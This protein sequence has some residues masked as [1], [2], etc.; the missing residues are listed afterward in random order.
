MSSSV[1]DWR[2]CGWANTL[3]VWFVCV[4]VSVKILRTV[5]L[6]PKKAFVCSSK[7]LGHDGGSYDQKKKKKKKKNSTQLKKRKTAPSVRKYTK[8][9][10]LHKFRRCGIMTLNWGQFLHVR[11]KKRHF[12]ELLHILPNLLIAAFV[13]WLK[14]SVGVLFSMIEQSRLSWPDF[15]TN[16]CVNTFKHY[17]ALLLP[18]C[19]QLERPLPHIDQPE[20]KGA[21]PVESRWF[22]FAGQSGAAFAQA[23]KSNGTCC[24]ERQ[25]SHR[26]KKD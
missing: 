15:D 16:A 9:L 17:R 26:S 20:G 7:F 21:G 24:R 18:S 19:F 13:Y 23:V 11:K 3:F 10:W 6:I 5:F 22:K 25:C 14:L 1:S 2:L 8:V 12:S 4:Q